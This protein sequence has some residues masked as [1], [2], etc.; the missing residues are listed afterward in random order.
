MVRFLCRNL[1]PYVIRMVVLV[2]VVVRICVCSVV[3]ALIGMADPFIIRYVALRRGVRVL[4]MVYI[5]VRLVVLDRV[6]RGAFM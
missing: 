4:A 5:R 2:G 1:G 3:V 6:R